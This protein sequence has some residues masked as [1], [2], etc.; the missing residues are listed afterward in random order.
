LTNKCYNKRTKLVTVCAS[1]YTILLKLKEFV[2]EYTKLQKVKKT[3]CNEV[4]VENE[5]SWVTVL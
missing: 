5:N 4:T 3:L 2:T 1:F